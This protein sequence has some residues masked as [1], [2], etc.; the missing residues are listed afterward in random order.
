MYPPFVSSSLLH[1]AVGFLL[2]FLL[3]VG[4]IF[5]YCSDFFKSW[6]MIFHCFS[7]LWFLFSNGKGNKIL[8]SNQKM[9]INNRIDYHLFIFLLFLF[10]KNVSRSRTVVILICFYNY[11]FSAL[12]GTVSVDNSFVF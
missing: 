10:Y 6:D 1:Y 5:Q 4:N 7:F 11:P 9:E 2:H 3:R 8:I 12:A